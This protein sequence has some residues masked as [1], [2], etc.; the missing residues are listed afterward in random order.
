MIALDVRRP[1]VSAMKRDSLHQELKLERFGDHFD[2]EVPDPFEPLDVVPARGHED[3]QMPRRRIPAHDPNELVTAEVLHHQIRHQQVE[4]SRRQVL[5][6]SGT[7]RRVDDLVPH[8]LEHPADQLRTHEIVFR[9]E[10]PRHA[11]VC[12]FR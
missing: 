8:A 5:D 12:L 11:Q 4:G 7:I 2:V 10:D 9:V 1:I 6:C 3:R